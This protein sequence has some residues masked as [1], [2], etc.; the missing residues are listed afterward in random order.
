MSNYMLLP[1]KK[2][3]SLCLKY[4]HLT[5]TRVSS[6]I[7]I[8]KKIKKNNALQR[9][10]IKC[11]VISAIRVFYIKPQIFTIDRKIQIRDRTHHPQIS[12]E[13]CEKGTKSGKRDTEMKKSNVTPLPRRFTMSYCLLM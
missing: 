5:I 2:W 4:L 10:Q 1:I 7:Y 3:I 8:F 12:P 6:A 11:N 9:V 13:A